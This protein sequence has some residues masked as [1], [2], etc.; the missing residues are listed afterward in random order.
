MERKKSRVEHYREPQT[1]IGT[2]LS[3]EDEADVRAELMLTHLS[4]RDFMNSCLVS[5]SAYTAQSN[6]S[7]LADRLKAAHE[8]LRKNLSGRIAEGLRADGDVYE[9]CRTLGLEV[10]K[11]MM[12]QHFCSEMHNSLRLMRH[13]ALREKMM[14]SHI[15]MSETIEKQAFQIVALKR[16]YKAK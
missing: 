3:S 10:Q 8:D 1:M 6:Q 14:L 11:A 5:K 9:F 16:L 12:D 13:W 2:L 15:A 7:G 4:N